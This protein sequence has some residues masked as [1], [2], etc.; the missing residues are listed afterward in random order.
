MKD[1]TS[2]SHLVLIRRPAIILIIP[3]MRAK[4]CIMRRAE[5]GILPLCG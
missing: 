1:Y 4:H 3:L 2:F 5:I